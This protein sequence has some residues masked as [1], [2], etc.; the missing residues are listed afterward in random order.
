MK[1]A[2]LLLL[3]MTAAPAAAQVRIPPPPKRGEPAV[4]PRVFVLATIQQF[5][6]ADTFDAVFG[7]TTHPFFGGGTARILPVEFVGGYRFRGGARSRLTPYFGGGIGAFNYKEES[8]FDEAEEEISFTKAGYLALAG[9]EFRLSRRLS[10]AVDV[11]YS[12]VPGALGDGGLSQEFD[13]D[14]L[15]GLAVRFRLMVGN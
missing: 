6:A 5:A 4:Q 14:D 10:A 3:V 9:V 11:Q 2:V 12:R 8:E 7:G 1:R 13:E 15:G